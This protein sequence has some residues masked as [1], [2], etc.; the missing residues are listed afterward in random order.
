MDLAQPPEAQRA[1]APAASSPDPDVASQEDGITELE[2]DVAI[3]ESR[4]ST[5]ASR[6]DAVVARLAAD[7]GPDQPATEDVAKPAD[8]DR[9]RRSLVEGQ[10]ALKA[11]ADGERARRTASFID[12]NRDSTAT[13]ADISAPPLLPGELTGIFVVDAAR[14]PAELTALQ[15]VKRDDR[16]A[17][18]LGEASLR[19]LGRKVL[20]LV[21]FERDGQR[22]EAVLVEARNQGRE[23]TAVAAVN[24]DAV[25]QTLID[26]GRVRLPTATAALELLG[27]SAE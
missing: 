13:D 14:V 24:A 8:A 23:T 7:E 1:V 5:R 21:A 15:R 12:G 18:R 20:A 16:L 22:V 25:L 17:T 27:L 9:T 3:L 2:S 4:S 11:L 19:A 6:A 10:A 26:T